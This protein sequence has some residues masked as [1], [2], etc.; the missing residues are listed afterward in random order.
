MVAGKEEEDAAKNKVCPRCKLERYPTCWLPGSEQQ[1]RTF[2]ESIVKDEATSVENTIVTT[3]TAEPDTWGSQK[4]ESNCWSAIANGW[5]WD[6]KRSEENATASYSSQNLWTEQS[7]RVSPAVTIDD[8]ADGWRCNTSWGPSR[9]SEGLSESMG[10]CTRNLETG[11]CIHWSLGLECNQQ[12]AKAWNHVD[13]TESAAEIPCV[14][15]QN[16]DTNVDEAI[17]S[18]REAR[19]AD[20]SYLTDTEDEKAAGDDV[21]IVEMESD[22]SDDGSLWDDV[23]DCDTVIHTDPNEEEGW[24]TVRDFEV[25]TEADL[26]W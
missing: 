22:D 24:D 8:A 7:K 6:P 17:L 14:F 23:S 16:V 12:K 3:N 19:K 20:Y 15:E 26:D 2:K 13:E 25:S 11:G 10:P 21:L 1:D 18:T 4:Y 9:W 5:S